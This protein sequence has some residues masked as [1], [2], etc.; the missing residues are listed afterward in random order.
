MTHFQSQ[1]CTF[2]RPEYPIFWR[3]VMRLNWFHNSPCVEFPVQTLVTRW[4]EIYFFHSWL[5]LS[6][7]RAVCEDCRHCLFLSWIYAFKFHL[8]FPSYSRPFCETNLASPLK[9]VWLS[10]DRRYV[11]LLSNSL[12]AYLI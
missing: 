2:N 10:G 11:L 12:L 6:L 3:C 4:W 1:P 9:D 8:L 7:H 5:T